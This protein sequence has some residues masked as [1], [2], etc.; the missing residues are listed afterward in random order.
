MPYDNFKLKE[1]IEKLRKKMI[2][3]GLKK[4]LKNKDTLAYSQ[5]LDQL[6]YE[7]QLKM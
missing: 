2:E 3:D 7:Y 4:G 1:K 5:E 6:I